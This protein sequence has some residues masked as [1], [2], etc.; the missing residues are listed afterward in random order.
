MA[1]PGEVVRVSQWAARW[2]RDLS[3]EACFRVVILP[4]ER[5]SPPPSALADDRIV[6]LRPRAYSPVVREPAT[7]SSLALP[8][9]RTPSPSAED[10]DLV[11]AP[12]RPLLA[13]L[14]VQA[15]DLLNPDA[16]REFLGALIQALYPMPPVDLTGLPNRL[17]ERQVA[18]LWE[19][20][21]SAAPHGAAWSALRYAPALGL[22]AGSPGPQEA[23]RLI[24]EAAR[25][26]G[27]EGAPIE[28]VWRLL[29]RKLSL[30]PYLTNL[31]LATTVLYGQPPFDL[32]LRQGVTMPLLRGIVRSRERVNAHA[33]H[34]MASIEDVR[35]C[36]ASVAPPAPPTWLSLH[37]YLQ[38][39]LHQADPPAGEAVRQALHARRE[40]AASV[41]GR[42]SA[43]I[44]SIGGED[45]ERLLQPVEAFQQVEALLTA[46]SPEALARSIQMTFAS[47]VEMAEVVDALDR[48]E[49][50]VRV[51]PH[52]E[53]V[54]RYLAG[55]AIKSATDGNDRLEQARQTL[56]RS[57]TLEALWA[58]PGLWPEAEE[59][60]NMFRARYVGRYL[61]AH[62]GYAAATGEIRRWLDQ[63]A[64]YIAALRRLNALDGLGE[65]LSPDLL[66]EHK[67][68]LKT[69]RPCAEKD[70]AARLEETPQC[71]SCKMALG[72]EPPVLAA[73]S[74]LHRLD[75]ALG[76]QLK[77]LT[78]YG[79]RHALSSADGDGRLDEVLRAAQAND[80]SSLPSV[81]DDD[82]ASLMERLLRD[83]AVRAPR[84]SVLE[85]LQDQFPTVRPGQVNQAAAELARLLR[86]EMEEAALQD[87]ENPVTR[88]R[89]S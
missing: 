73:E 30:P 88:I 14:R 29:L 9:E 5:L 75:R 32:V 10:A 21:T 89:L 6:V 8:A 69:M 61:E 52:I 41:H 58:A 83:G 71:P 1:Y 23:V 56:L 40:E 12:G 20:L 43:L 84:R 34:G 44:E 7:P 80:V 78:S 79:V 67:A 26:S 77:R 19:G 46:E 66:D 59:A 62:E 85:R 16:F 81:L 55:A 54:R 68:L 25:S 27:Q 2:G 64:P 35:T 82:L 48:A 24:M 70:L 15:Q 50:M 18:Y 38:L 65:P 33:L 72:V 42:A 74:L 87:P 86:E 57:T 13:A 53:S 36:V 39:L 60:F 49:R 4:E 47:I 76:E 3:A 51:G 63:A 22:D 45:I 31:Y 11:V 17:D 37:P 28:D